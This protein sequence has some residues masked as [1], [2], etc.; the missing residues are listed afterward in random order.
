MNPGEIISKQAFIVLNE[1]LETR[2]IGVTNTGSR[3]IQVGSHFHFFEA[4]RFLEFD[5]QHAYG[6]RLDIASGTAIRLEPGE[7]KTVQLVRLGGRRLV[8]GLN[9][10]TDAQINETTLGRSLQKATLA[11]FAHKGETK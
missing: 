8:R 10:L 1:G 7:T 11:G 5:R 6:F 9:N 3:P 4:N 2:S